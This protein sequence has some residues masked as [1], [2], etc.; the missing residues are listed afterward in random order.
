MLEKEKL[1]EQAYCHLGESRIIDSD[2]D[3]DEEILDLG[4]AKCLK[5]LELMDRQKELLGDF[6]SLTLINNFDFNERIENPDW[7]DRT[8]ELKSVTTKKKQLFTEPKPMP[9]KKL[10]LFKLD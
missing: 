7:F 6:L 8:G 9:K 10:S 2:Q 5:D 4:V 1:D 3:T